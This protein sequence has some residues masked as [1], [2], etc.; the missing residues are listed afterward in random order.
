VAEVE[1]EGAAVGASSQRQ[2]SLAVHLRDDAT[3]DNFLAL[4]RVE[5]LLQALRDQLAPGGE[6]AIYVYGPPGTGKSHLLQASCH[7]AAA[8]AV[9]LPLSEL[10]QYPAGEVLQGVEHLDRV[11]LDDIQAI[12]GDPVWELALF[13]FYNRARQ[14]GCRLVVAG[15]AAPR[16]LPVEL[17]DLRSRLSWGIVY[18]LEPGSD[19]DRAAILQFRA[20]RRGLALSPGVASYIVS[21][22]PRAM[23]PLLAVLDQLDAASLAEQRALSIPFVKQALGW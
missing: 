5:P 15:D 21:R 22:A 12:L 20:M 19:E 17:A 13:D 23:E 6:A 14:H 18:Q 8:N 9:Y 10:R 11:C 2:L 4:P 7:A 3:L 1:S 16:V